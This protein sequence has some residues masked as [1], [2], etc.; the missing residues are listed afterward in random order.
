MLDQNR[1]TFEMWWQGKEHH[2]W[3]R[4]S[5]CRFKGRLLGW[6]SSSD[7]TC[8]A[9]PWGEVKTAA[10]GCLFLK[11][12]QGY[13]SIPWESRSNWKVKRECYARVF[14]IQHS[15]SV[16]VSFKVAIL[17]PHTCKQ[18]PVSWTVLSSRQTSVRLHSKC[19]KRCKQIETGHRSPSPPSRVANR[20]NLPAGLETI[21]M[22][23]TK[24]CWHHTKHTRTH[25]NNKKNSTVFLKVS[26][27]KQKRWICQGSII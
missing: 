27:F 11:S 20:P 26:H 12:L 4:A 22:G 3:D 13:K 19:L 17:D 16:N 1:G 2:A 25:N 7:G 14:R 15:S 6:L 10:S 18:A 9:L 21:N 8:P 24:K 5:F 23:L